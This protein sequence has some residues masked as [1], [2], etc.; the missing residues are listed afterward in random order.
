MFFNFGG[1]Q[2]P[3]KCYDFDFRVCLVLPYLA[4]LIVRSV[5]SLMEATDERKMASHAMMLWKYKL[6][7]HDDAL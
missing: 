4:S 7:N 5:S 3:H 2:N 1:I 6:L